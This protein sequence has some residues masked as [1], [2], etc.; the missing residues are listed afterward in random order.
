MS[1]DVYLTIDT[2]IEEREVIDIGNYTYNVAPM[3]K[4]AIT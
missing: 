3:Y 4:K 1:W 2:G